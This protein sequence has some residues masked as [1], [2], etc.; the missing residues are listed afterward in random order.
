[1]P[2]KDPLDTV[3]GILVAVVSACCVAAI[4]GY[5]VP[6]FGLL[7]ALLVVAY[8][9]APS[10]T[11]PTGMEILGDS[12]MTGKVALVTGPTSGIGVE[13]ARALA[14][15]GAH[16]ILAAR[17]QAKLDAVKADIE[18]DLAKK[19]VKAQLTCLQCDLNNLDSVKKCAEAFISLKLPL[20]YL[21]NNAGIMALPT[22]AETAQGI[23]QQTGV[24]H[25]GHFLLTK[26]LLPSLETSAPSRVICLSSSAYRM[27]AGSDLLSNKQLDT[28]P[29]QGWV[30][31]GNAKLCNM[32]HAKE[33]NN[34][35][36]AKGVHAFSVMPG[37]IHTGLQGHVNLWIQIKWLVVTP[38]FF[39]S[40]EQGC[41]T[42]LYAATNPEIETTGGG[43]YFENCAVTKKLADVET[44]LGAD[45]AQRCWTATDALL[46]E[47]GY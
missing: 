41:A 15:K 29:Y 28:T 23:E 30:A 42:T 14:H 31:Y 25:V 24:C 39:K 17:S 10:R 4:F 18:S 13:T 36:A 9:K 1:M 19:G 16:V 21:I 44:E 43:E 35:F 33:L 26:M 22:R 2:K 40:V 27:H 45:V 8:V 37:G 34:R 20:H 11:F 6:A 5:G 47:L 32:L 3:M 7:G 46:R 12:D 38:F